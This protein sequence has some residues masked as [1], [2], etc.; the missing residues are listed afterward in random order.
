MTDKPDERA[1]I[2]AWLQ[3]PMAKDWKH[4]PWSKRIWFAWH[5]LRG[6]FS[7]FDGVRLHASTQIERGDYTERTDDA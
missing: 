5:I 2:V 6:H 3:K 4:K 7:V 1:L